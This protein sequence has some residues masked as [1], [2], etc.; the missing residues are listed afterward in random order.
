[1]GIK[2]TEK[3]LAQLRKNLPADADGKADLSEV[4]D[5]VKA[6]TGEKADINSVK[7]VLENLGKDLKDKVFLDLIKHRPSK[8]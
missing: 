8:G 7:T 3:E 4:M 2:L 1:M 6:I 5:G